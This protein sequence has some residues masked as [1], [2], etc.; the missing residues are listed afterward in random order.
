MKIS[1]KKVLVK[2]SKP[3]KKLAIRKS[4]F[5]LPEQFLNSLEEFASGGYVLII[6]NEFSDPQVYSHFDGSIQG[7]GLAK[8][9]KDYFKKVSER[10]TEQVE[11]HV[12]AS[13]D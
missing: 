5:V 9:G 4:T 10:F 2:N 13:L 12:E 11:D 8:F 7:I 3:N 1:Q 6:G